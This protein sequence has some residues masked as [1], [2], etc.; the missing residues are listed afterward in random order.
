MHTESDCSTKCT[1]SAYVLFQAS[2]LPANTNVHVVLTK[3]NISRVLREIPP[4]IKKFADVHISC[5][6]LQSSKHYIYRR[7]WTFRPDINTLKHGRIV[8]LNDLILFLFIFCLFL[9][10]LTQKG[11][12]CYLQ[13]LLLRCHFLFHFSLSVFCSS[14][15]S[16]F[17]FS[18]TY[19]FSEIY[20][21]DTKLDNDRKLRKCWWYNIGEVE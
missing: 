14:C 17:A 11:Q 13:R 10:I 18:R 1:C 16:I 8:K 12:W 21:V 5:E 9:S 7:P 19:C 3:W 20:R 15:L 2:L 6:L 4:R